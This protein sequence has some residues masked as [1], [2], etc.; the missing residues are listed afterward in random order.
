[1]T[2]TAGKFCPKD[3]VMDMAE[4]GHKCRRPKTRP[5]WA[6]V[7]RGSGEVVWVGM[8]RPMGY[9]FDGWHDYNYQ[10]IGWKSKLTLRRVKRITLE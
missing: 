6:L 4:K 9:G 2:K 3:C 10:H 5:L 7:D 1:M 8:K